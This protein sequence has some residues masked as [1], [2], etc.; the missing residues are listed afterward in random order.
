MSRRPKRSKSCTVG[1]R[2]ASASFLIGRVAFT[3]KDW[4]RIEEAPGRIRKGQR[5]TAWV[6]TNGKTIVDWEAD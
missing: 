5:A 2:D 3:A 4:K 1:F 6:C